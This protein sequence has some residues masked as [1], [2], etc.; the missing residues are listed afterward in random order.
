MNYELI[1]QHYLKNHVKLVKKFSWRAG[2]IQGGEDVVHEAYYRAIKYWKSFSGD[3]FERWFGTIIN[4]CL[5]EY[6]NAEK[7]FSIVHE[8]ADEEESYECTNYYKH[9]M[10]DVLKLISTKS[11]IQ[12]EVLSLYFK[13]QYS[14]KSISEI[15]NIRYKA[16]H[17][18]IQRFRNELKELYG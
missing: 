11:E 7:G 4:N 17:Q 15:T 14:P 18:I 2:T 9:L 10:R 13:Q 1:E 6:K 3:D 16:C 5:R 8:E 12:Q